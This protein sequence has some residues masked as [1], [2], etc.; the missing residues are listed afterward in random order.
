MEIGTNFIIWE[1]LRMVTGNNILLVNTGTGAGSG[2]KIKFNSIG[3]IGGNKITGTSPQMAMP[4]FEEDSAL[5]NRF[6]G[7]TMIISFDCKLKD[8]DSDMSDGDTI[9]TTW[10]Q[11]NYL[12]DYFASGSMLNKADLYIGT[13][14]FTIT[15]SSAYHMKR[16]GLVVD[17]NWDFQGGIEGLCDISLSFAVGVAP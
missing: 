8:R 15:P 3:R 16:S 17:I 9:Q 13:D 14:G 10:E 12:F 5:I 6:E 7:A 4:G 11:L 2:K 1:L